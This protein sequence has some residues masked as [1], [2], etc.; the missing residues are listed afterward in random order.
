MLK[1]RVNREVTLMNSVRSVSLLTALYLNDVTYIQRKETALFFPQIF[2]QTQALFAGLLL[3]QVLCAADLEAPWTWNACGIVEPPKGYSVLKYTSRTVNMDSNGVIQCSCSGENNV[4]FI[5]SVVNEE[6]RIVAK[7][8]ATVYPCLTAA[9]STQVISE[10]KLSN[11]TSVQILQEECNKIEFRKTSGTIELFM[12][13]F[14]KS[15]T[16]YCHK[17]P[18]IILSQ[19][20]MLNTTEAVDMPLSTSG[21]LNIKNYI[22]FD[23]DSCAEAV[24]QGHTATVV[25]H[26]VKKS[27]IFKHT[28]KKRENNP[29]SFLKNYYSVEVMEN[30]I[31]GTRVAVVQASDIDQGVNGELT[32][33]M[34]PASNQMSADYFA[35]NGS[36][37]EI[38][39]TGMY[40]VTYTYIFA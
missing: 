34:Q 13:D 21:T 37:G 26:T 23:M 1:S 40:G 12:Q 31:L 28:L 7:V 29:P 25:F 38:T 24:K 15:H 20:H 11:F 35:I 33:T 17:P 4:D 14:N 18:K 16:K 39:T 32:Y 36:S 19:K 6:Q 30:V 10:L 3:A 2:F 5:F 8:N 22:T 9:C 27:P